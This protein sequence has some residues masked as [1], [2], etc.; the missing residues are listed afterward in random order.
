MEK[1]LFIVLD[2][3]DGSGKATQSKLLGQYFEAEGVACEKVDFPG[4]D[5]NFFGA[6]VGECLAGQHGDFLHMDPKVASTLYALDRF[7]SAPRIREAIEAGKVVIADRYASSNQI[8]QGGKIADETE[9]LAFLEWLDRM[10]YDVVGIPRPDAIIYLRVPV[11]TSLTLLSEKRA[12]KNQTLAAGQKDTVEE[13]RTY[14]ER[15]HATANWLAAREGNWTVI[16][17]QAESGLRSIEDIST[18]V[19]KVAAA[20]VARAP[21]SLKRL[22]S[23]TAKAEARG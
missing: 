13:D 7:E 23:H 14:L 6:F 17:C 4:Y 8:H 5:R 2:G 1:G 20:L 15:S 19:R 22:D 10:E 9:R 12:A 11:E 18:E 16:D 21:V 3:N